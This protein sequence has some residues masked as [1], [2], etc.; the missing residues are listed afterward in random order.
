MPS[1]LHKR[2]VLVGLL[3]ARARLLDTFSQFKS[4]RQRLL[5]GIEAVTDLSTQSN[6]LLDSVR[7]FDLFVVEELRTTH[8][9]L[10]L[11]H[12]HIHTV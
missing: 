6:G 7:G 11:K 12:T 10:P 5:A 8:N 4:N 9:F 1:R 3:C 2:N